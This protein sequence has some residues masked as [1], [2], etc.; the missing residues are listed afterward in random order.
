MYELL[1]IFWLP[2]G[3]TAAVFAR[4]PFGVD[5]IGAVTLLAIGVGVGVAIQALAAHL[6]DPE[7]GE[8]PAF[9]L[10]DWWIYT[11]AVFSVGLIAID[12]AIAAAPL[13]GVLGGR[14]GY[15]AYG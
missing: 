7:L 15:L 12:A 1:R 5:W 11:L 9:P 3:L 4:L 2:L 10:G 6:A 13:V 14:F 8:D